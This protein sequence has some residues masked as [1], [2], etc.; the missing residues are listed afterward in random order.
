[1]LAL[2]GAGLSACGFGRHAYADV[3][4]LE[5]AWVV[6]WGGDHPFFEGRL[7][8]KDRWVTF[9]PGSK[10]LLALNLDDGSTA[11]KLPMQ[12]VC[13]FS[14]INADGLLAVRSGTR[15]NCDGVD[16]IDTESGEKVWS[17]QVGSDDRNLAGAGRIGLSGQ[18]VSAASPCGV[19]RWE[20][21]SGKRLSPIKSSRRYSDRPD[22]WGVFTSTHLAVVTGDKSYVGYDVDTGEKRWT[23]DGKESRIDALYS[24]DPLVAAMEIDGVAGR[25]ALDPDS[26]KLGPVLG[27]PGGSALPISGVGNRIVGSYNSRPGIE[28]DG[29]YESAV[30]VWDPASGDELASWPGQPGTDYLGADED[31]VLMG[32]SV[33]G[34]SDQTL[35]AYW[36][37]RARWSGKPERTLGWIDDSL[38][39]PIVVGGLLIDAGY[40]EREDGSHGQ[41][42]VAY[43]VPRKTTADP[44]PRSREEGSLKWAKG[45]VR[46]DPSIDPCAEVSDETLGGVGFESLLDREVPLGCAWAVGTTTMTADVD[47]VPPD[48]EGSA[49]GKAEGWVESAREGMKAP[50]A[51]DGLGDEAWVSLSTHVA[52][53]PDQTYELGDPSLSDTDIVVVAR[54]KNVVARVSLTDRPDP[55]DRLPPA[56]V[57]REAGVLAALE[58]VA[59]AAGVTMRVPRVAGDGP[60]TQLPDMCDAVAAGV[61]KVLPAAKPTDLTAA[62]DS[63]LRGCLWATRRD[64]YLE[65]HVQVVA[66]AVGVSPITGI[67]GSVAAEKVF[68]DSRGELAT[69]RTDEKWDESAMAE[70]YLDGYSDASHFMVRNDNVVLVVD[71]N[72]RDQ[73]KPVASTIAPRIADDAMKAI[74]R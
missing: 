56:A 34:E 33:P 5:A 53:G 17:A 48:S 65:S 58:D 30:R 16:L 35:G 27:R 43:K 2:V 32:I 29:T 54:Q 40:G 1:M 64:G 74:R 73:D 51:V 63:R 46:P 52:T 68:A 25:R 71:I 61:R 7:V 15:S 10:Q 38:S 14:E 47:V 3:P 36:V 72:L 41:R 22:C 28:P 39:R 57:T 13:A 8:T 18:T 6:P 59:A 60:I 12:D 69:S 70:E 45:D 31:G 21:A 55:D 66:Y 50:V 23:Q 19:E 42:I 49:V 9:D 26:G 37:T 44:I 24:T 4:Q 67:T 20:A 11:W 62:G